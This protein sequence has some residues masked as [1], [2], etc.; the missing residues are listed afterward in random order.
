MKLIYNKKKF[1]LYYYHYYCCITIL[2][3]LLLHNTIYLQ[4]LPLFVLDFIRDKQ[5]RQQQNEPIG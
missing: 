4:L 2:K 5:Q 3:S 1:I